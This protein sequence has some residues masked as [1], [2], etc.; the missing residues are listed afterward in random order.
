VI[1]YVG[2]CKQDVREAVI[3][4]RKA[5]EQPPEPGGIASLDHCN[6]QYNVGQCYAN[7][8]PSQTLP[9]TLILSHCRC[10]KEL[11]ASLIFHTI[12]M[13]FESSFI[14]TNGILCGQQCH[15]M[16][17]R[18]MASYDVAR[19]NAWRLARN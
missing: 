4:W 13:C 1:I 11:Y 10:D 15:T 8:R 19:A 7:G 5:A 17:W 9:A 2:G 6:A 14:E 12:E 18:A 16:T 3:W